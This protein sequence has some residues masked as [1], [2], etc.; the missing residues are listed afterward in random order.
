MTRIAKWSAIFLLSSASAAGGGYGLWQLK[1]EW[2]APLAKRLGQIETQ[3]SDGA[4]AE[5]KSAPKN[6]VGTLDKLRQLYRAQDRAIEG[7]RNSLADQKRILTELARDIRSMP[8]SDL[9]AP[10][11]IAI[12]VGYVLSGGNAVVIDDQL[13]KAAEVIESS[14]LMNGLKAYGKRQSEEALLAFANVQQE[15]LPPFLAGQFALANASLHMR[16]DQ[17]QALLYLDEARLQSP[18]TA[19]DEAASR[20]Q[21]SILFSKGDASRGLQIASRYLRYFP[22]SIYAKSAIEKLATA[23]ANDRSAGIAAQLS[24]FADTLHHTDVSSRQVLFVALARGALTKGNMSVA[25]VAAREIQT[26]SGDTSILAQ[27]ARLYS[28][29]ANAPTQA[30]AAALK[31]LRQ[32]SDVAFEPA[33][34]DILNA[35][36]AVAAF[37]DGK[38]LESEKSETEAQIAELE[39]TNDRSLKLHGDLADTVARVTK[40]VSDADRLM[41]GKQE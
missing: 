2:V 31:E 11:N 29:A 9:A 21:I 41:T 40:A 1:P 24:E 36:K 23:I 38:K 14:A 16:S 25:A 19:V 34:F 7:D 39:A 17:T 4:V 5:Q 8:A 35:A 28:A 22:R 33:D 37:V 27:Q 20:W 26:L 18:R 32:I 30:A 10:Y 6:A 12:L 13:S 15:K 3:K